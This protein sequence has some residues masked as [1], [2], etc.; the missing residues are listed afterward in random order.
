LIAEIGLYFLIAFFEILGCYSF[1]IVFKSEKHSIYL[2]I[3]ITSLILFAYLFTKINLQ[4]AGRAYAVYGGIY[5]ISSLLWLFFIEKES[6]NRWD[7]IGASISILGS[8][9]ILIGNQKG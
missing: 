8:M 7:I 4:F 6:F 3:G 2:A 5:I 1:W 9:I